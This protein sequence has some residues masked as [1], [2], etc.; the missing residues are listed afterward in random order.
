MQEITHYAKNACLKLCCESYS[1]SISHLQQQL[2][3]PLWLVS[4]IEEALNRSVQT[5]ANEGNGNNYINIFW[6]WVTKNRLQYSAFACQ[7]SAHLEEKEQ[8]L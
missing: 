5:R 3:W 8:P 2:E 7:V 6:L 1:E 4:F